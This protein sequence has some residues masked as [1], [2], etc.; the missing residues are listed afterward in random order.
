MATAQENRRQ[1]DGKKVILAEPRGFCAG[2]RRAIEIVEHALEIH[3]APVYV[4]KQIVHNE[5][6]VRE[7]EA[8]G[9]RFVDSETEIPD[10]AVCIVVFCLSPGSVRGLLSPTRHA[11]SSVQ[12]VR[13]PVDR[14]GPPLG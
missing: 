3:G 5:H 2:V 9:V 10:G 12:S 11:D 1:P 7:L 14:S 4:R 8:R 6:V 13:K